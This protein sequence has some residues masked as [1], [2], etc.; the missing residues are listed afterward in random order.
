VGVFILYSMLMIKPIMSLGGELDSLS[1]ADADLTVSIPVQT[2]D[3]I[4]NAA[5]SF[6]LFIKKLRS[7]MINIKKAIESTDEIN[8]NV[9]S[10]TE[11]TSSSIEQIRANLDSIANQVGV[12]DSNITDNVASIEEVSQNISSMDD[13]IINQSAMVEQSTAP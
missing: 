10:S 7:L 9:S 11:E 13:Q 1:E 4:G 6:N 8:L 12:L 2:N 3:E 5:A